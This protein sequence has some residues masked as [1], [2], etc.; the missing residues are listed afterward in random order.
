M[1]SDPVPSGPPHKEP[2]QNTQHQGDPTLSDETLLAR[3]AQ[4]DARAF[5]AFVSRHQGR[6]FG[7]AG[8]LLVRQELAEEAAQ[9]CFLKLHAKIHL[10]RLGDPALRWFFVIVHRT[11]LDLRRRE[12]K[13]EP[14]EEP[15]LTRLMLD[16][17]EHQGPASQ[18]KESSTGAESP[19]GDALAAIQNLPEGA[20]RL[21]HDR[22]FKDQSFE[23]LAKDSNR[24][25]SALRKAYSR[26]IAK[27]RVDLGLRPDDRPKGTKHEQ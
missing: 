20:Q 16:S 12:H 13:L 2:T 11:C 26:L 6:V 7:Y 22:I 18:R 23:E 14:S 25:A 27:L 10:Y 1:T 9:E 15:R 4:G 3:Y 8:R 17:L 24:S 19:S 5:E 21:L